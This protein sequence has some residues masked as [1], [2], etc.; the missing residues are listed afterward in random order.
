MSREYSVLAVVAV[1]DVDACKSEEKQAEGRRSCCNHHLK[2]SLGVRF[3]NN[4]TS[5]GGK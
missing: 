3:H 1:G 5:G 4:T 2:R